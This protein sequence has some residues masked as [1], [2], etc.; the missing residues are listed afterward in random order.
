MVLFDGKEPA[1]VKAGVPGD[2]VTTLRLSAAEVG[3]HVI[4][5]FNEERIVARAWQAA[6][7]RIAVAELT[8]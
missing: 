2:S 7:N 8:Y 3:R 4:G 6:E 5:L 1:D